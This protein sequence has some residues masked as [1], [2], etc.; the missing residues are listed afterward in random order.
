MFNNG[1]TPFRVLADTDLSIIAIRVAELEE[2]LTEDT[3][4]AHEIQ[5]VIFSREDVAEWILCKAI[6]DCE[7]QSAASECIQVMK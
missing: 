4:L 5:E 1:P 2:F 7:D 3:Q 6:P